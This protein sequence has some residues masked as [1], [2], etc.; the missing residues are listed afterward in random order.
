M[1]RAVRGAMALVCLATFATAWL[2]AS[3]DAQT[4]KEPVNPQAAALADFQRRLEAY[5][6]LHAE[7]AKGR[8]ELKETA[9]P[10][11]I[12]EAET[13][14]AERIR[15]ARRG[16]R[17]GDIF[18]PEIRHTLRRLMYPKVHGPGGDDAKATI[19][20]DA[21]AAVPLKV[22]ATYPSDQPLPTVPATVLA[23]LP[24]LPKGLEYRIVGR[25]LILRDAD[26]NLIVDYI[27]NAVQ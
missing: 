12:R 8:G 13:T 4:P 17:Q 19:R 1:K 2:P 24:R 27:P 20:E 22:N 3:L 10:A 25:H 26:A 15:A 14:L 9:N 23:N 16:A 11:E 7:A 5:M 6:A 21:P 18:T